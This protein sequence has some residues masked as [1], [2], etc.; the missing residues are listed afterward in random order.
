MLE[1]YGQGR[2]VT[3]QSL[4]MA[5]KSTARRARSTN[6][7]SQ[8]CCPLAENSQQTSILTESFELSPIGVISL[9][10]PLII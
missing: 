6:R 3:L 5:V 1:K 10:S 4:F 8:Y 2:K 9:Y 7:G